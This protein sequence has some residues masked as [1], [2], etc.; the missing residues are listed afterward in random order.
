MNF[1]TMKTREKRRK[2]NHT[3]GQKDKIGHIQTMSNQIGLTLL[4]RVWKLED[5]EARPSKF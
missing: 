1:T 4:N 2:E 5:N 3:S